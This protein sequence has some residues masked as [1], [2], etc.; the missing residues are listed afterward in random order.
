MVERRSPAFGWIVAF[1]VVFAALLALGTWQVERLQWKQA[2]L[3]EIDKNR[4]A[5]PVPVETIRALP[6]PDVEGEYRRVTVTG[7]FD[8]AHEQYFFATLDGDV[9]YHVYTPLIRPDGRTAFINRGFVPEALKDP[10]RRT[11]G[12]LAGEVTITGLYRAPL[13]AKPSWVTPENEPGKRIYFWK[14]IHAM[15]VA[16]SVAGDTLEPY[17]IDADAAPNPGGWPKGGVTQVDLP[18]NHLSYA[19]TWYGLAAVLLI[20]GALNWRKRRGGTK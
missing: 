12:Q 16:A 17:F 14:D 1:L 5:A 7:R 9:G 20:I 11:E 19:L 6:N 18:N 4:N 2:L 3:V 10:A 15:A 8:H 13:A